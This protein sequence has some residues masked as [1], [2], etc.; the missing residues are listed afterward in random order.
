MHQNAFGAH[1]LA[2]K[3][4]GAPLDHLAARTFVVLFADVV[5]INAFVRKLVHR[6]AQIIRFI[7]LLHVR[8]LYF[9]C[10]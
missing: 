6:P 1:S 4:Y 8:S 9:V 10:V 5:L 7:G 2:P 3:A